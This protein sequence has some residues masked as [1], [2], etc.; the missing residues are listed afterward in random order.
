MPQTSELKRYRCF[1]IFSQ[2]AGV[3]IRE[4]FKAHEENGLV[5]ER[6]GRICAWLKAPANQNGIE[7]AKIN[8]K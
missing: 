8:L 2:S 4:A 7:R 6:A 3:E 1:E 5:T